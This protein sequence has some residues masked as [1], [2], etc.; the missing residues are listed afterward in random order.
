MF[1]LDVDSGGEFEVLQGAVHLLLQRAIMFVEDG[2][3][4]GLG[5]GPGSAD[6]VEDRF[7]D[8][9]SQHE[10]AGQ[11]ADGGFAHPVAPGFSDALHQS[12]PP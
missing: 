6:A 1:V 11:R 3:I 7:D 4:F 8:F 10:P 2:G 5:S 9:L 12:L